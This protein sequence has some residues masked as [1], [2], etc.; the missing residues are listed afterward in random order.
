MYYK[1]NDNV[2]ERRMEE[3]AILSQ[4]YSLQIKREEEEMI[5]VAHKWAAQKQKVDK[6]REYLLENRLARPKYSF[7]Y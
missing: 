3:R 2:P 7:S 5:E 4:Q 1:G 6:Q